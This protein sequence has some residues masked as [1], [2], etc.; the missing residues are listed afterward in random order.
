VTGWSHRRQ[1]FGL[2]IHVLSLKALI[3]EKSLSVI[4]H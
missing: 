4:I 2:V 1:L 3:E